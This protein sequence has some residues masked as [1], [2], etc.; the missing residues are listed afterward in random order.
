MPRKRLIGASSRLVVPT[1]FCL[2]TQCYNDLWDLIGLNQPH[3]C[4]IANLHAIQI[5]GY[6]L[7]EKSSKTR[8]AVDAQQEVAIQE[9]YHEDLLPQILSLHSTW[10][11][12]LTAVSADIQVPSLSSI[13][14]DPDFYPRTIQISIVGLGHEESD[15]FCYT[16]IFYVLAFSISTKGYEPSKLGGRYVDLTIDKQDM[17]RPLTLPSVN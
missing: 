13:R 17:D 9:A 4:T 6:I 3:L 12:I 1:T 11:V 2:E 5:A 14:P 16:S 10:Q 7:Y 8:P 15:R